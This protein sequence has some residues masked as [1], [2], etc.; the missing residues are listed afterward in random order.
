MNEPK[1]SSFVPYVGNNSAKKAMTL[2][3]SKNSSC[4]AWYFGIFEVS[5]FKPLN[6]FKKIALLFLLLPL[7]SCEEVVD[8]DLEESDP[9]LVIEA[10]LL[11]DFPQA[12]NPL[13]VRLSTT[14]PYFEEEIPPATGAQVRVFDAEG[15][16]YEFRET[17]PGLYLH[18]GF[19]AEEGESFQ[20]EVIYEDQVYQAS[21]S[22]VTTPQIDFIEQNDE[23]GFTGDE[24]ELRAF[25]TDPAGKGDYYFFRF[26]HDELSIQIYDDELIDGNQSFASFSNEDLE[27]GDEVFFELQSISRGFY[28]YLFILRSQAG[29]GGG[30]FQTQP[31]IVRGNIVNTTNKENFAFGYFRLS[32]RVVRSYVIE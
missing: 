23:G 7:L 5:N 4:G 2:N 32:Q 11:W 10:S 13:A 18:E 31:T 1:N 25:Y 30:P 14:A 24:I 15:T 8:V 21:E 16:Q 3:R 26:F 28:D 12:R 20:L 17:E 22:L 9:R 27:A 19:V 29:S 6:L